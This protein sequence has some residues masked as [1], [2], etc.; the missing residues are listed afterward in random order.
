MVDPDHPSPPTSAV[1]VGTPHTASSSLPSLPAA[2]E[3]TPIQT[4]QG[5]TRGS[6]EAEDGRIT[7]TTADVTQIAVRH[8]QQQKHATQTEQ[9]V[10]QQQEAVQEKQEQ[11]PQAEAEEDVSM[12]PTPNEV[13]PPSQQQ[14]GV[15]PSSASE[16]DRLQSVLAGNSGDPAQGEGGAGQIPMSMEGVE[17]EE[18]DGGVIR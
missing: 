3:P 6:Q 11:R 5:R 10:A 13:D 1:A 18:E 12:Q 2:V 4:D 16:V 7:D 15:P 9:L 8:Q 14:D 17:E